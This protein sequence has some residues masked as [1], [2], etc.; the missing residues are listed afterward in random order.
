LG[1]VSGKE[2]SEIRVSRD[3]VTFRNLSQTEI[4]FLPSV[5]TFVFFIGVIRR[6]RH[7]LKG[8][9][10]LVLT[11][12][13]QQAIRI[14]DSIVVTVLEIAGSRVKVGIQAA[15]NMCVTR[16]GVD[17]GRAKVTLRDETVLEPG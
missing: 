1:S 17:V 10:V 5:N 11:A 15:L 2:R 3:L 4:N 13:R 6:I 9:I 12:A 14:G 16:H 7:H 8:F